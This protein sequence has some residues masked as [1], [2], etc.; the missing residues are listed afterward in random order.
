[1]IR[2]TTRPRRSGGARSAANGI[3]TCP[4]TDAVPTAMEARPNTQIS[5][6]RAHATRATAA[7]Q[8]MRTTRIRRA[9]MI[10]EAS[11][12]PLWK[13]WATTCSTGWA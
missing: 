6:D 10:N 11:P 13:S 12:E 9:V 3:M 5:G 2:A 7:R 4:A 8:K 1:M